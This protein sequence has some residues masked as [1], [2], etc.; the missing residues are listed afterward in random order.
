MFLVINKKSPYYQLIY[1]KDGKR[2]S[3]STG[4]TS[5][6]KAEEYLTNFNPEEVEEKKPKK[7]SKT[8]SSFAQEYKSYVGNTHSVMYLKKSV[9]PSFNRLQNFL[10]N[11]YLKRI[12]A[13]D[14]DQFISSVQVRSKYAASLYY[15]TLKAAF[16]KAVVWN[17]IDKNPFSKINAP[18]ISKSFPDYISEAELI[19]VLNEVNNK[20]LKDIITSAFYTGMRLGELIN[21]RWEW[22][23]LKKEV[24]TVKNTN[25]FRT[26]NKRE[27]IIPIHKKVKSIFNEYSLR[28]EKDNIIFSRITGIK[29]NPGYLSKQFKKAVREAKLDDK[30]HFHSLRHSF[31]SALVQRGISLYTVK[32]LLGHSNITTTQIYSHLNNGNLSKAINMLEGN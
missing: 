29:L 13:K 32:E 6:K 25:E 21:M 7:V 31:A 15:R 16:N 5:K 17:Y 3:I 1:L 22:I 11:E 18:K 28:N 20:L 27:R 4:T 26:K 9:T 23:D 10:P 24:I 12:T 30:I 14:I 2:S 19:L 8:L